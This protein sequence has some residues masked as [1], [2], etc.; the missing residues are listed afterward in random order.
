[1]YYLR[2]LFFSRR[3]CIWF[4]YFCCRKSKRT[5]TTKERS[6]L[7]VIV[8][9]YLFISSFYGYIPSSSPSI[10]IEHK[11][12]KKRTKQKN[13]KK[14]KIVRRRREMW[15]RK[16]DFQF[17]KEIYLLLHIHY[18][19]DNRLWWMAKPI[20]TLKFSHNTK[21]KETSTWTLDLKLYFLI[22]LT[23]FII[24]LAKLS[25]FGTL[26]YLYRHTI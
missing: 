8:F 17:F 23:W 6:M 15:V 3:C 25:V 2:L 19:L 11:R 10:S 22:F 9:V 5:T 7:C 21:T 16:K 1:M 24:F 20:I 12:S 14:I 4:C 18:G 26:A 13:Y